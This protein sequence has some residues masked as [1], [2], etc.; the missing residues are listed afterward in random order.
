M[1]KEVLM[2]F[3]ISLSNVNATFTFTIFDDQEVHEKKT[4]ACEECDYKT[5]KPVLLKQH[6]R[7]DIIKT[8]LSNFSKRAGGL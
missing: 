4:L 6:I 1:S 2:W 7:K 8:Y 5:I 3:S